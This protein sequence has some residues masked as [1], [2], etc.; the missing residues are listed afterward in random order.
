MPY[1]II[2][3][4]GLR[5]ARFRVETIPLTPI[6]IAAEKS[7]LES[8]LQ[9][10]RSLRVDFVMPGTNHA[11]F[12][13]YPSGAK[14]APYGTVVNDLTRPEEELYDMISQDYRKKIRRAI[15]AGVEIATG[16]EY[17]AESYE[18]IAATL[19]RSG[20]RFKNRGTFEKEIGLGLG[21]HV[22]VFVAK[23]KGL[24]HACL[25]VPFSKFSGYTW[26]GGTAAEPQQGA[27]H[28]I[29][30]EAMKSLKL[31]GVKQ[32][33]F[34]GLRIRPETGSKQDGIATFK[35]RFGGVLR[36][37]Y[38]WKQGI[39]PLKFAAYSIAVRLL[40]G[41]DTVDIEHKKLMGTK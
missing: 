13:T 21:S 11:L 8:T 6:S 18:M 3:K 25:V 2:R 37:G 17:L 9:H 22:K 32:F 1:T 36:Q 26:Y 35:T 19:R 10:L 23:Q 12:R 39:H 16:N 7:L 4:A 24:T 20:M 40:K 41:G 15:K 33:N 29:H 30:W 27:M 5:I 28:L 31:M 34:S 38:M 14:A